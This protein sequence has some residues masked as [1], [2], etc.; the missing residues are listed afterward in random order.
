MVF[1]S[2]LVLKFLHNDL[3]QS[4]RRF[5]SSYEI[6]LQSIRFRC[7]KLQ[8]PTFFVYTTPLST[9]VNYPNTSFKHFVILILQL[10]Y[11]EV[12]SSSIT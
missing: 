8:L 5:Q 11:I 2:F 9:E 12:T 4:F 1:L 6:R 3:N 7:Y 10:S